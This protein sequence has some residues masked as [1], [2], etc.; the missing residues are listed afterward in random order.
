MR[1]ASPFVIAVILALALAVG[2]TG[3]YGQSQKTLPMPPTFNIDAAPRTVLAKYPLGAIPKQAAFVHHG[4]A[5][6][7]VTLPNGLEG[8]VYEVG[9]QREKTY[10]DPTGEERTVRESEKA[11]GWRTYTLVFDDKG[12]V[13]DVLYNEE[14]RHDGLSALQVQREREGADKPREQAYPEQK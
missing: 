13:V 12:M 8:W 10:R 14:G 5:V 4:K 6:K 9:G 3:S 2:W 7:T 1:T 11:F